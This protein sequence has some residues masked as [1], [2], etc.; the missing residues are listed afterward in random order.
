MDIENLE[1]TIDIALKEITPDTIKDNQITIDLL[2]QY[3]VS[4]DIIEAVINKYINN[5]GYKNVEY[6]V[7]D[8]PYKQLIIKFQL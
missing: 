5:G 2:P 1:E 8:T 4:E 3:K 7:V 6:K